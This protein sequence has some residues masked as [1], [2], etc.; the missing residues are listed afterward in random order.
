MKQILIIYLI[1]FAD[2]QGACHQD[3][4]TTAN[5]TS[6]TTTLRSTAEITTELTSTSTVATTT[7]EAGTSTST[8]TEAVTSTTTTPSTTTE[9]TTTTEIATTTT[10]KN[11][12]P[13]GFYDRCKQTCGCLDLAADNERLN[14]IYNKF[15][16]ANPG[17]Y[18]NATLEW[19]ECLRVDRVSCSEGTPVV[20]HFD[21]NASSLRVDTDWVSVCISDYWIFF[22]FSTYIHV[23]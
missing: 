10:E 11:L 19:S 3:I 20:V 6:T 8:S 7:T 18:V 12:C 13:H 5:L 16:D 2:V 17:I 21:R 22:F 1:F 4:T 23:R 15:S 9:L 14:E